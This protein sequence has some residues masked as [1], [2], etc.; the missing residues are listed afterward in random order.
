MSK[1]LF[2]TVATISG[3][4][5]AGR[6]PP[7]APSYR[8]AKPDVRKMW[9]RAFFRT[10]RVRDGAIADFT[11]DEP[12]ASLLGSHKGSMVDP[13]GLEPPTSWLPAMCSTN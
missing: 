5:S 1:L 12:F 7:P 2:A 10:I 11:Y 13:G 6:G 3:S 8:K 9:N 4:R